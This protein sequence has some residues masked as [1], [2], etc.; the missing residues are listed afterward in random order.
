MLQALYAVQLN[1]MF[2][3]RTK[4]VAD[5]SN[6]SALSKLPEITVLNLTADNDK[7]F[8]TAFCYAVKR[9]IGINVIPI[10][11]FRC[12]VNGYYDYPWTT[13]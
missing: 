2:F 12:G 4:S 7:I 3:Q 10:D 9:T 8:T 11:C 6:F 1:Y 5:K 13:W